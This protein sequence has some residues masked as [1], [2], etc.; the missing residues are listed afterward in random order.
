ML[1]I[2]NATDKKIQTSLLS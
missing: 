2:V 1:I